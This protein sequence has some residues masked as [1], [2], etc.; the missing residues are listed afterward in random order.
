MMNRF[1]SVVLKS[2][3]YSFILVGL[4]HLNAIFFPMNEISKSRNFLF[5]LINFICAFEMKSKHKFFLIPF[6]VLLVQQFYSHGSSFILKYSQNNF[7]WRSVLVLIFFPLI[8]TA[9]IHQ[10]FFRKKEGTQ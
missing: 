10:L 4:Y 2:S 6:S 9:F 7:D 5:V 1:F 8:Y 3:F